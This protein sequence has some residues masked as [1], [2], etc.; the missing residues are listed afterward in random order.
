VAT[1]VLVVE[2]S[3]LISSALRVLLEAGGYD[4]SVAAT[5]AEAATMG[6]AVAP[7]V[8]ILDLTLPDGD[9]LSV[10]SGLVERGLRPQVTLAMT[11]Y[12]DDSTRARCIAAGCDEVL[13]KPV[14]I[15]DLLDTIGRHLT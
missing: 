12:D 5:A 2:D 1:R 10:L 14:P 4:V 11:G 13:L 15:R 7:H 8:L 9:G 3:V 6:A